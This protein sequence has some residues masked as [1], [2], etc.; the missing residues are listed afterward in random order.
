MTY[1]Q[2]EIDALLCEWKTE[3]SRKPLLLRGARQVGKSS[4]VRQL[5][6]QFEYF[7]EINFETR[8]SLAS[9]FEQNIDPNEI[10]N[11][12]AL[13][14]NTPIVEGKTLL[15]FDEIQACIP[16]ISSLRFFY[17]QK[18]NLHLIAAGSLLEFALSELPSFGVGRIRSMFLYPF[19]LMNFYE[20]ITSIYWL[21]PSEKLHQK[22]HFLYLFTR[23]YSTI[24]RNS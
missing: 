20:Q 22:K 3:S 24:S 7:V 11:E 21:M 14:T 18:P 10:C 15:F 9:L 17:E 23:N 8:P 2:R 16:A 13:L 19:L 1:I 6:K 4:V 5:G 12:L